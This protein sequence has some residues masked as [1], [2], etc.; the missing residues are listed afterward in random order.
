LH[1]NANEDLL[2]IL[3]NIILETKA[4]GNNS[5]EYCIEVGKNEDEDHHRDALVLQIFTS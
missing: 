4:R 5:D 3:N 2:A 1:N